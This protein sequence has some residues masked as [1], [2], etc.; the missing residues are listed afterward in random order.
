[1]TDTHT[2]TI[3]LLFWVIAHR[4]PAMSSWGSTQQTKAGCWDA[5]A[6]TGAD[7]CTKDAVQMANVKNMID[8]V[9]KGQV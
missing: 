4:Y 5:Y 8:A 7:Y 3:A 1:V 9:V 6:Q 2:T